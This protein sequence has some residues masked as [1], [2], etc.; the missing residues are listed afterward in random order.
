MIAESY[1]R[2]HRS[3]LVGMGVLPLQF[4][5]GEGARELALDGTEV[6]DITGIARGLEPGGE[7][8]VKAARGDG[9]IVHFRATV[10]LDS[11]VEL[12]YYRNGGILH[13]VLRRLARERSAQ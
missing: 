8:E 3:N 4:R 5:H 10:R 13:T 7:V 1:E 2:I 12:A 9:S 11:D 6:Y